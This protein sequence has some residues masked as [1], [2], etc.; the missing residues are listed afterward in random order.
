MSVANHEGG[1]IA[2]AGSNL[3]G[4]A[5]APTIG[6]DIHDLAY[7]TA[8]V[9]SRTNNETI[10]AIGYRGVAAISDLIGSVECSLEGI[11][12]M[13]ADFTPYLNRGAK[14][15]LNMD[16]NDVVSQWGDIIVE[17]RGEDLADTGQKATMSEMY[18]TGISFTF[19]QNASVTSTWNFV[20]YSC[21]WADSL[22]DYTNDLII[23]T[24]T[25]F[26][27]LT[28]K[29]VELAVVAPNAATAAG[30]Q[31]VSFNATLNRTEVYQLGTLAPID[32][33]V[34]YP[35][36]V[37][38]NVEALA[39]ESTLVRNVTPTYEWNTADP[40]SPNKFE[41]YVNHKSSGQRIC[42]CPYAR[43]VDGSLNVSVGNNSTITMSFSGWSLEF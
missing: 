38:M 36:E 43:P 26:K 24:G 9:T 15:L 17:T 7:Q 27:P 4:G 34:T 39:D 31:S 42:G 28:A 20:G 12:C 14:G 22:F 16:L 2:F 33:P 23:G 11:L 3:N 25:Q 1:K 35:F 19:N 13:N 10:T 32:R 5:H 18:V 6:R 8:S 21:T 40:A 30:I 37:T 41:V 29:D